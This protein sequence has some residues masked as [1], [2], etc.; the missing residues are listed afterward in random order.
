MAPIT[1]EAI[2]RS[3]WSLH[4]AGA[5]PAPKGIFVQRIVDEGGMRPWVLLALAEGDVAELHRIGKANWHMGAM[6]GLER[7]HSAV[8]ECPEGE[9]EMIAFVSRVC[10]EAAS[11]GVFPIWRMIGRRLL[12][13]DCLRKDGSPMSAAEVLERIA[14]RHCIDL[15]SVT[16]ADVSVWREREVRATISRV[17]EAPSRSLGTMI[18]SA[19]A[20]TDDGVTFEV[21]YLDIGDAYVGNRLVVSMT[22]VTAW[23]HGYSKTSKTLSSVL[24]QEEIRTLIGDRKPPVDLCTCATG[25]NLK[26]GDR[27]SLNCGCLEANKGSNG[28]VTEILGDMAMVEFDGIEN[29]VPCYG[30]AL[31]HVGMRS[32]S[33]F[34][35]MKTE[36]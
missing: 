32:E 34:I 35:D 27:V 4:L 18:R 25:E 16:P 36:V 7:F 23:H 10:E 2:L 20:A 3:A 22:G 19:T 28:T 1:L 13:D 31:D 9:A 6:L 5:L 12:G 29:P 21:R 26:A 11:I 24:F 15:S 17:H 8:L 14:K 33:R 30:H